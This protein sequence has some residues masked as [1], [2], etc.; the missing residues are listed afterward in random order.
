MVKRR[1]FHW[2]D[3]LLIMLSLLAMRFMRQDLALIAASVVIVPYLM[4]T[5]RKNHIPLLIIAFLISLVWN[6]VAQGLYAYG[7]GEL[8]ISGVNLYSLLAW[9][10]G[11]F[12]VYLVYLAI[13]CQVKISL[14]KRAMIFLAIYWPLIIAA[15][16]LA[17]HVFKFRNLA[18]TAY[19]GLPVCDCIHGPL[20]L[21]L[22]YL[23]MGPL[24]FLVC[25]ALRNWLPSIM[26]IND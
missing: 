1:I 23:S 18:A 22:A 5:Q 11:L 4:L 16:T 21:Q 3:S 17:Y 14:P 20:W 8:V 25:E 13:A 24:Y 26:K 12:S 7:I 10:L 9:A 15:E 2:S 19:P 6:L